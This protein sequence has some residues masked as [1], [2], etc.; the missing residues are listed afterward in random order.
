MPADQKAPLR[1]GV[2]GVGRMGRHHARI[3]SQMPEVRLVGVVDAD[4]NRCT[5]IASEYGAAAFGDTGELIAAGVDAVTVAV[6]TQ[7]HLRVAEPLL[8]AGVACLIEKPLAPDVDQARRLADLA[9]ATGTILQVGHIERYNPAVRALASQDNLVPRFI[10]VHRV[11][12]MTFRSVDVGVVLDIMIHDLDVLL[13][14]TGCEPHRVQASAVAVL[15]AAEDV[16]NARLEFPIGCVANVTASRLA[17]KTERKIR[18]VADDAYVS[19]DFARK[20]GLMIRHT[21]NAEQ[22]ARVR[23]QLAAGRD[24][25]DLDYTDLVNIEPLEVDDADQL[26]MQLRDFTAVVRQGGRPRVDVHAGFA[27]V[28]T[29]ERIVAAA[30]EFAASIPRP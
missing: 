27:A 15:G 12:P 1:V 23:A 22:L 10:E 21:A 17:L 2:V 18:I 13:M 24:L 30:R 19:I 11:S 14:L 25:S 7:Y 8:R 26:Q 29:A 9:D 5:A 20:N 4:A 16:C 28:R 3:Y 6:P